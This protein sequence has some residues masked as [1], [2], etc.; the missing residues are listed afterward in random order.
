MRPRFVSRPVVL[1]DGSYNT[2]FQRHTQHGTGATYSRLKCRCTLCCAWHRAYK[3]RQ[4]ANVTVHNTSGY[5]KGCRCDVC[6]EANSVRNRQ[7]LVDYNARLK[8][9]VLFSD[10]S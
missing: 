2:L 4:A 3:T 6:K 1:Q 7:R 10:G 5:D 9:R 8:P